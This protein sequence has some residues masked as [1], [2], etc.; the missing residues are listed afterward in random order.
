VE[1]AVSLE[2][3][4][5]R[6]VLFDMDGTLLDSERLDILAMSRLFRDDLGLEMD[7]EEVSSYR[8]RPSREV[9]EEIAPD[10]VEESL[11]AWLDYHLELVGQTHLFPGI[12]DVLHA[13]SQAKLAL[14]VVTGQNRRE[15]DA[16]RRHLTID[17]LIDVWISVDDAPFSKPHPAPVRVA[18]DALG[19]PPGQAV[20]IGDS[21]V[22]MEAGRRAGTRLAAALWGLKDPVPLLACQPDYAFSHPQQMERLLST[23]AN[24]KIL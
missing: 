21:Q 19:C 12:L 15:L 3:G 1:N 13:L 7:E 11:A 14:G 20:F 2:F 16:T 17:T 4:P 24:P 6:A 9:L 10:R 22:D 5:L 18:L 8:N 23:S